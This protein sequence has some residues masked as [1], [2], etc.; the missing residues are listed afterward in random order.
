M[1]ESPPADLKRRLADQPGHLA[2]DRCCGLFRR[3]RM[4]RCSRATPELRPPAATSR[5]IHRMAPVPFVG[6]SG[7][8]PY[9]YLQGTLGA[10]GIFLLSQWFTRRRIR[11]GSL[12]R[13]VPSCA[14][15]PTRT[16]A[17][18]YRADKPNGDILKPSRRTLAAVAAVA[19]VGSGR[20][21]Y[22]DFQEGARPP[23]FHSNLS[24][25]RRPVR[26]SGCM[27]MSH[28]RWTRIWPR[29]KVV[30]LSRGG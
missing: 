23:I 26:K 15:R 10:L 25:R 24:R 4:D 22:S 28:P 3:S 16:R 18:R 1:A 27:G 20:P 6:H 11:R 12:G 7:A 2:L 21:I 13:E 29:L 14:R 9:L 19:A 5:R 30:F 8:V 17:T